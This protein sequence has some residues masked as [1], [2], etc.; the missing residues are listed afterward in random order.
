M[1]RFNRTDSRYLQLFTEEHNTLK[2]EVQLVNEYKLKESEEREL[3]FFLSA[4]LRN[5][6]EKERARVE[7]IKYLQLGL[8]VLCTS[9][10]ILSA[11]LFNYFR[12]ANIREILEFERA[13]FGI[14]NEKI[15]Q[16]DL[17]QKNVITNLN[18]IEG[19][20]VSAAKSIDK[21]ISDVQSIDKSPKHLSDNQ[22]EIINKEPESYFYLNPYVL[23]GLFLVSFIFF[24]N[25]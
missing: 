1:E 21:L 8:S 13:Q 7:R 24:T 20:S 22:A 3:F 11:Y 16:L 18:Q 15:S 23:S 12:N 25:K 5:A 4:A 2:A 10:G 14:L 17:N 19:S 6:Q 9:L